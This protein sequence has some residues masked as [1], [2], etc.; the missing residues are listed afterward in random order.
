MR[1]NDSARPYI[2]ALYRKNHLRFLAAAVLGSA[3]QLEILFVSWVLGEV[4]D[5][6][7]AGDAGRLWE[8]LRLVAVSAAVMLA[9]NLTYERLRAECLRRAAVQYKEAAFAAISRKSIHAFSRENTG[10]YIALLTSDAEKIQENYLAAALWLIPQPF[11]I[12][13]MLWMRLR[14]SPMLTLATLFFLVL[15]V[16][17]AMVLAPEL[18]RRERAASD[19]NERFVGKI[20]DLLSGFSVI[21]SF[22]AEEE[23]GRVFAAENAA[24]ENRRFRSRWWEGLLG[25]TAQALGLVTQF[26]IFF[27]GAYLSLV[28]GSVTAGTVLI[29]VNLSGNLL[30]PVQ[31]MPKYLAARRAARGLIGKLA[32]MAQENGSRTGETV[33]PAVRDSIS[34]EH[35]TFGYEPDKPVLK[36]LNLRF[37]AG[38]KYALVGA[39]GSGK[40]TLLNLLM[41]AYDG[42]EGSLTVDGREIR[43]I[44]P[45]SLYDLMSLIEQNVFIFDDTLRRNI[46]MFREFPAAEVE[47]AAKRAG[48]SE[49]MRGRGAD[50]PC[51]ENGSGLSGR[52]RQRIS[53]GP[54]A[55]NAGAAAG[56]GHGGAGQSDGVFGHRVDP[57]SGGTD[58][59]RRDPP[60]GGSALF[61]V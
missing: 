9:L 4:L 11:L 15:P 51:G 59:A 34:L 13:G 47:S 35:L 57:G 17:G 61:K 33:E 28:R 22:K 10:R 37:A 6:I 7:A 45:D 42:Y 48:L 54:A 52:E 21:K 30:N 40:S 36:D 3:M 55:E 60:P 39:S 43:D 29:F 38:K 23:T 16:A 25:S 2:R 19:A 53:M 1:K 20:K 8:V 24:L 56:R 26:G 50:Y 58:A 49:L 41:G 14:L 12:L 18:T 44:D 5:V 32:D 46:T 27:T 31:T